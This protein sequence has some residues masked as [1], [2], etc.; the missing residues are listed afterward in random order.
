MN[1][2]DF[3]RHARR[4]LLTWLALLALMLASL[5]SSFLSLGAG[6]ALAGTGIAIVKAT[7]VVIVFMG[8][9]RTGTVVRIVAATALG[10]WLVQLALGGFEGLTRSERPAPVQA[11][12][13][14]AP[15]LQ[16]HRPGR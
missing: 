6:N 12:Q 3:R 7:L 16:E 15:L 8:V 14:I 9:L 13:Q 4:L 5:G 2:A 1:D 11:P 10:I